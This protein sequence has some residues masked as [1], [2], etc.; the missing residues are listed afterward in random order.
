MKLLFCNVGWM[1]DYQGLTK[2]D[3]IIRGGS[4]IA[5]NKVGHEVCNF[6]PDKGRLFGYV[7][8]PG[9]VSI[10]KLGAAKGA[11]YVDGVTVVWTATR[12]TGGNV[13]VGWYRNARVYRNYQPTPIKRAPW[14]RVPVTHHN[15]LALAK[16][17][18]R[19]DP[20]ARVLPVPSGSGGRG[21]SQVWYAGSREGFAFRKAVRA[22]IETG[23]LPRQG[24]KRRS[25]D[26]A[27]NK[28]VEDAAI[29]FCTKHFT[30]LGYAVKSVEHLDKGWDLEAKAGKTT[31]KIEVKGRSGLQEV[32][33]LT[34][35]EYRIFLLKLP[36]YRLAVVTLALGLPRLAVTSF[37][38]VSRIWD[39]DGRS[40]GS[41]VVKVRKA[42]QIRLS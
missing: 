33:E 23:T 16:N 25:Q 37:N 5:K 38:L 17:A 39:V 4:Y 40:S 27:R 14:T 2:S 26:P 24:R 22:L 9:K 13:V 8:V 18:V 34:P 36:S 19:L 20:D 7:Q 30:A 31:L 32:I 35:N 6:L 29:D 10:E 11:D 12:P 42:A 21:Q 28:R 41:V 1:R 15:V 3:S